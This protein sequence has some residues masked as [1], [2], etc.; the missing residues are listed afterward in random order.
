MKMPDEFP[1]VITEKGVTAKIRKAWQVKNEVRYQAF[2][3][4]F[5]LMGKRKRVWRSDL[6]DAMAVASEACNEIANGTQ[7]KLELPERDRLAYIR[8]V[9][10][11]SPARVP[12]D[13][14]CREYADALAILE[15]KASIIEACREWS[16][17]NAVVLPRIKIAD[18][19]LKVQ[20]RASH[21]K[22]SKARQHELEVLLN[23]FAESF[24]C[25]AHVVTPSLVSAHLTALPLSERSKRN[26][27]DA[28]K[29]L[30]HWLVLHG[31]LAKGTDWM[32]GV[33]KYS[34]RKR[35]EVTIYTSEEMGKVMKA[36]RGWEVAF[37]SISGFST[38]RHSELKRLDWA[39]VELSDKAGESFIEILPVEGTKSDQR[40][41][42]IPIN[43]N[44]RA[45][46][47]T[48]QN[49]SGKVVPIGDS[50]T[51]IARMV[52]RAGVEFKRNAFR[53]SAISYRVAQTGDV[54]R[55]ADESGNSVQVIR[56]N[57]LR[58]VKPA[59]SIEW[60]GILPSPEKDRPKG[61]A[62]SF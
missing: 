17:R 43:D 21:D 38:I 1:L 45:W 15:G 52:R 18:A 41:R 10:S 8:A 39:Q 55:V 32:D 30:N 4:E 13:T 49:N 35:G 5:T 31:Y 53:H 12:I 42:L 50:A 60:F 37:C 40:R 46:L 61:Q 25:E 7:V 56:T 62:E 9:E 36:A 59:A 33:Q 26:H 51:L 57:Y 44:L 20:Q 3:I 19:V 27:Q 34:K 23:R 58:R 11:L 24:Q 6:E 28:I 48:C 16:K 14:A 29:H 22:K 2:V 54:A 47:R